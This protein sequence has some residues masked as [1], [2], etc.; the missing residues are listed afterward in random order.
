TEEAADGRGCAAT[1][2]AHEAAGTGHGH[3]RRCCAVP[4]NTARGSVRR[5]C[6]CA[7]SQ[8]KGRQQAAGRPGR[9]NFGAGGP[10]ER[11]ASHARS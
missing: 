8:R 9:R 11:T 2:W 4:G 1:V 7:D 10:V 3:G 6:C 5:A